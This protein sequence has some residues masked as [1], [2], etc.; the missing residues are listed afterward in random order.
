MPD[1]LPPKGPSLELDYAN[2]RR[3]QATL[4]SYHAYFPGDLILSYES[5]TLKRYGEHLTKIF[6]PATDGLVI[7]EDLVRLFRAFLVMAPKL[8]QLKARLDWHQGH[9]LTWI[10]RTAN[11]NACRWH[12][13]EK[14]LRREHEPEL[15]KANLRLA[16]FRDDPFNRE[17]IELF[18]KY[19]TAPGRKGNLANRIFDTVMFLNTPLEGH[20]VRIGNLVYRAEKES[21]EGSQNIR[22]GAAIGGLNLHYMT[23]VLRGETVGRIDITIAQERVAVVRSTVSRIIGRKG[24]PIDRVREIERFI[25]QF[26]ED[27]RFAKSAYHQINDLAFWLRQK[28]KPLVSPSYKKA[29]AIP[30]LLRD[31]WKI[32]SEESDIFWVNNS[33]FFW[34][35][36]HVEEKVYR[37]FFSPYQ[38]GS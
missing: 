22:E 19:Y 6:F 15:F 8:Q 5:S 36:R 13:E 1:Y 38:L 7:R 29:A 11:R 16:G 12:L 28:L 30:D 33:N 25:G 4:V 35:C 10:R 31:N 14:K 32:R 23:K 17:V 3:L 24:D 27:V 26:V 9:V 20:S 18:K 34:D 21:F 2:L 37:H